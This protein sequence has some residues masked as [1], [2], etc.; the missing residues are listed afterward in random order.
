MVDTDF[1]TPHGKIRIVGHY[2]RKENKFVESAIYPANIAV[3]GS[4][5]ND[6]IPSDG[7]KPPMGYVA[8][9]DGPLQFRPD[10]MRTAFNVNDAVGIISGGGFALFCPSGLAA[11]TIAAK[12]DPLLSWSGGQHIP[13]FW[14]AGKLAV[15]IP[16]SKNTSETQT[17]R[18]P[19][20]AIVR[21]V[22]ADVVTAV[23]GATINVGTL[24]T[25]SGDADGFLVN[26]SCAVA[27][28]VAHNN[29]DGT[30]ANNTLGDLL[31][32]S[33]IKSADTTSLYYSVPKP[34]VV[35]AGGK[36]LTYSTSD[37]AITGFILVILESPGVVQM[38]KAA[39]PADARTAAADLKVETI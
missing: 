36:I 39:D 33:D 23:S 30:A 21:D 1:T 18:L 7:V 27:G 29:V 38:G 34:Y 22:V 14:L 37:H 8:L 20:G 26:E 16:F 11:K 4:T 19:P 35:P 32:E 17:I 5:T 3:Q 25:D 15:K 10:D 28:I 31:V 9:E 12:D 6:V 13:G 24:S 2:A